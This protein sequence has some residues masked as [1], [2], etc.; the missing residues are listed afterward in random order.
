MASLPLWLFHL[1]HQGRGARRAG[2]HA[3]QGRTQ[4]RGKPCPY[5]SS[6]DGVKMYGQGLPLPRYIALFLFFEV[7]LSTRLSA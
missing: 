3:G 2:A 4:G 1:G 6:G 5:I 7:N